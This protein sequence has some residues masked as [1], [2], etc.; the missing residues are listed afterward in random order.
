MLR[1]IEVAMAK[2]FFRTAILSAFVG[3]FFTLCAVSVQA[4]VDPLAN[5]I[6]L[7]LREAE[8]SK[9]LEPA[10]TGERILI[11]DGH[12]LEPTQPNLP[13]KP[14][15][16]AL[17]TEHFIPIVL[18][19]KPTK[20]VDQQGKKQ[21]LIELAKPEV[22]PLETFTSENCGRSAAIVIGNQI[23]T[24]HKIREPIR[25]GKM[26]ITRCTDNGCDVLYT[27]LQGAEK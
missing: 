26:Q 3:L 5:G 20:K 4:E 2:R 23:V 18:A 27:Q 15:F 17:S 7:V 19:Q 24:V 13:D 25:G 22:I 9:S 14:R 8:N 16:V 21:L 10:G 6:Y 1:A 12:L 11:D